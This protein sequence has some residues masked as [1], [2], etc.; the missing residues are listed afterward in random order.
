VAETF[1]WVE[2][3]AWCLLAL[4]QFELSPVHEA[5]SD[6]VAGRAAGSGFCRLDA[7]IENAPL[8]WHHRKQERTSLASCSAPFTVGAK[9]SAARPGYC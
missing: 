6:G 8:G 7:K 5:R 1:S 4:K 9:E 3:T 2:P